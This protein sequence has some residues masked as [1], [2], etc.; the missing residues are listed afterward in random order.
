MQPDKPPKES[1]PA[2]LQS[3]TGAAS[4][5]EA[6]TAIPQSVEEQ[7][8]E[9]PEGCQ[10]VTTRNLAIVDGFVGVPTRILL[11]GGL[12]LMLMGLKYFI[13]GQR[14]LLDGAM[15]AGGGFAAI[16][17]G[18][19]FLTDLGEFLANHYFYWLF[20]SH[21]RLRPNATVSPD[22]AEAIFVGIVPRENWGKM[23]LITI[24]DA[25]FLRVDRQ[26]RCVLFE[27]DKERWKAPAGSI[28]SCE[29]ESVRIGAESPD[30][31]ANLRFYAV[32]RARKGDVL[33]ERPLQRTH[34]KL[35]FIRN[36]DREAAAL[37]LREAI[38]GLVPNAHALQ[39]Y[40]AR[41]R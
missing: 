13:R 20:R 2:T 11:L 31:K 41:G 5:L 3:L 37:L 28:I 36:A 39:E 8:L 10:I 34:L 40:E 22:D 17:V 38:L 27:G 21:F 6:L 30:N 1:M 9:P 26:S 25:G 24:T 19:L 12:G 7:K 23:I 15:L 14:P 4:H 33:W 16:V 35:G 29:V 18:V 32:L